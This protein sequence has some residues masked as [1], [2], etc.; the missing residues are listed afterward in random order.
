MRGIGQWAF[1]RAR[2]LNAETMDVKEFGAGVDDLKD[3]KVYEQA[4]ANIAMATGMPLS[5]LMAN[6]A[7]YATAQAEYANWLNNDI[8]PL[9]SW[10]AYEYNRQV[11]EPRGFYLEFKPETLDPEQEDETERAQ[12]VSNFMDFLNKCPTEG[13]ALGTASTF[14]YE[15]SDELITA[16]HEF[17]E[18]KKANAAEVAA[19]M[20]KPAEQI[21]G[22]APKTPPEPAVGQTGASQPAPTPAKWLPTLSEFKELSVWE[23][24]ALRRL[25]RGESMDFEYQPHHGGLPADVAAGIKAVLLTASTSEAVKAA[26]ELRP[27]QNEKPAAEI[28]TLADALN[29]FAAKLG[30]VQLPVST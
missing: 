14:G 17:Y 26:F 3:N 22:Q 5:L 30:A 19:N 6:S 25:K 1:R 8:I 28:L 29:N 23:E 13:L 2:V 9:C 12:A 10:M 15:L 21:P 16:I 20:N 24:V 7:N 4:L 18:E 27:D 11:F